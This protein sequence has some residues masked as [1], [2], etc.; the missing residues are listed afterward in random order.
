MQTKVKVTRKSI[1]IK[2]G[3]ANALMACML[4][5]GQIKKRLSGVKD[6]DQ[7]PWAQALRKELERRKHCGK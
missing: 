3:G 2:G 1:E 7:S 5:T 6:D 4:S